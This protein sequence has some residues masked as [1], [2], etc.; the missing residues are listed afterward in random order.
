MEELEFDGKKYLSSKRAAEVTGYAKDYIGQLCREGRVEARLVG[1]AWYVREDSIREH[2]FG[3]TN[4]TSSEQVEIVTPEVITIEEEF[5]AGWN[6][7]SYS[8]EDIEM[9]P[10]LATRPASDTFTRDAVLE[11]QASPVAH[12]QSVW[13]DWFDTSR[14][15]GEK[16][17]SE[18]VTITRIPESVTETPEE[19]VPI[20][21][22]P[23]RE[24][25]QEAPVL[26]EEPT[27][28]KKTAVPSRP[29]PEPRSGTGFVANALLVAMVLVAVSITFVSLGYGTDM[30][31]VQN[32][33]I[34]S[35][36]S[37]VS[38]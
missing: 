35:Y 38:K 4:E 30:L 37:G 15:T 33:S 12:M 14:A 25:F 29:I 28:E 11:T 8:S 22:I 26:R 21:R 2:R 32:N 17:E 1:R 5:P 27:V 34:I 3:P 6:T 10:V 9:I 20:Y 16:G 13:Q 23:M 19:S 36:L 7:A 31:S 18:E 24:S